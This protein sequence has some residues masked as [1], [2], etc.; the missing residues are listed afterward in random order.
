MTGQ[1]RRYELI[2]V[3]I[4]DG[5]ARRAASGERTRKR[6]HQIFNA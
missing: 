2:G 5:G 3:L 4:I 1:R 6:Q